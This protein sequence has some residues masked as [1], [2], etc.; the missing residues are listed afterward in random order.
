MIKEYITQIDFSILFQ[1]YQGF[2]GVIIT[3]GIAVWL[4][5]LG[6]KKERRLHQEKL[7]Y[8][9]DVEI[10]R[11]REY[12]REMLKRIERD[13]RK[14]NE[15]YSNW[16]KTVNSNPYQ[17]IIPEQRP[18]YFLKSFLD[19]ET[20]NLFEV[21]NFKNITMDKFNE[22]IYGLAY[23]HDV[24]TKAY[25][26]F[27]HGKGKLKQN[28]AQGFANMIIKIVDSD[29]NNL[30]DKEKEFILKQKNEVTE[31]NNPAIREL[32]KDY[33]NLIK[34]I[35]LFYN[36]QIKVSIAF[37]YNFFIYAMKAGDC[38]ETIKG[39]NEYD[40]KDLVKV[41]PEIDEKVTTLE[42]IANLM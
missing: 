21:C 22:A 20:K 18:H 5:L 26:D 15:H 24:I 40:K 11:K 31:K 10:N 25:D 19:N 29:I 28:A 23:L 30:S 4:F 3:G 37:H 34:P 35:I 1:T 2:I 38:R 42:R 32:E 8:E 41:I 7:D 6:I 13:V 9:Y 14:Q 33:Q 16:C 39:L 36:K 17:L 27:V 12:L